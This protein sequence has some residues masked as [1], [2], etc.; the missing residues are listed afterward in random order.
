MVEMWIN[1]Y[2][3]SKTRFS[4]IEQAHTYFLQGT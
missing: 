1:E 3:D 2:G 4:E